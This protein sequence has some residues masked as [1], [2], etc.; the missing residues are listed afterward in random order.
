[1]STITGS[2]LK[3]DAVATRTTNN[4][5]YTSRVFYLETSSNPQFPNNP[6]FVLKDERCNLVNDIKPGEQIEVNFGI[7]GRFYQ[8]SQGETK[9]FNECVAYSIA[10]VKREYVNGA[11]SFSDSVASVIAPTSNGADKIDEEIF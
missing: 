11:T 4:K 1:M 2:F 8:N 6:A 9:H 3:A 7:N 10:K 5:N